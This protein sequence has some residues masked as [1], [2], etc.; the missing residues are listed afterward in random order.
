MCIHIPLHV[1]IY[2]YSFIVSIILQQQ[3]GKLD[4]LEFGNNIVQ[5]DQLMLQYL[6]VHSLKIKHK[7]YPE[8]IS[9]IVKN[10]IAGFAATKESLT[11]DLGGVDHQ[12]IPSLLL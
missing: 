1:Y 12:F 8:G 3:S 6:Q 4:A 10:A 11:G 5:L 9:Q 2:K 7:H